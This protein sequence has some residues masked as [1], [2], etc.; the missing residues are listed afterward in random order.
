LLLLKYLP[1]LYQI[2]EGIITTSAVFGYCHGK[3]PPDRE[4]PVNFES[5]AGLPYLPVTSV[6]AR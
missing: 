5:H 2:G 4:H 3:F 1:K 6:I